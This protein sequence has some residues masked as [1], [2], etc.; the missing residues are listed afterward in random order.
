[1]PSARPLPGTPNKGQT[2][3]FHPENRG[4][5]LEEHHQECN[6]PV[7]PPPL[8]NAAAANCQTPNTKE[9]PVQHCSHRNQNPLRHYQPSFAAT[10]T[11]STSISFLEIHIKTCPMTP[12][13]GKA[14]RLAQIKPR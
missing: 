4:L 3:S 5:V 14:S 9:E 7:L 12:T 13:R 2:L 10:M 11:F 6:P 8:F 1:M